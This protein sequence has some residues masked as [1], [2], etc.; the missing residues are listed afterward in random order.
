[1]DART[2]WCIISRRW[3]ARAARWRSSAREDEEPVKAF[4]EL[5]DRLAYTPS[6]NDKL[7]LLAGLF[8][9][10]A[11][12]RPRLG[13]GSTHRRAVLRLPLGASSP[14]WSPRASIRCCSACRAIMSA[15]RPRPSP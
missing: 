8:R 4:A 12:S 7:R 1:M 11:G 10:G 15:T 3:A 6:R 2:R 14:R 9:R 13:A 5:L